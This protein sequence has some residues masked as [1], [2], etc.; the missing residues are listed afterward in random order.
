M[1]SLNNPYYLYSIYS[2]DNISPL[3]IDTQR[4][5]KPHAYQSTTIVHVT[6]PKSPLTFALFSQCLL[7]VINL[8]IVMYYLILWYWYIYII[9]TKFF[10]QKLKSV[11]LIFEY[12]V[13][14]KDLLMNFEK[15]LS[16]FRCG[17]SV[18]MIMIWYLV[19]LSV[20]DIF[21][22]LSIYLLNTAMDNTKWT[23]IFVYMN[24]I[25]G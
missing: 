5:I 12:N 10:F 13:S 23:T 20:I 17:S 16:L 25:M 19:W 15:K 11:R 18:G 22:L 3:P 24:F 6:P 1:F 2:P 21:V 8:P 14:V 9:K 4:E 7:I